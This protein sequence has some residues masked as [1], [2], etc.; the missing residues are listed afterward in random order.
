MNTGR[1]WVEMRWL[2]LIRGASLRRTIDFPG[3]DSGADW[4][5]SG[6]NW[7]ELNWA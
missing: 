6:L 3:P 1:A 5:C 4:N 2:T 7:R